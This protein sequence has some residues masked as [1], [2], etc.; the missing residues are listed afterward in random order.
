MSDCNNIENDMSSLDDTIAT[1]IVL[2][3]PGFCHNLMDSATKDDKLK[4]IFLSKE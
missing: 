1:I 2:H 4:Q 3:F